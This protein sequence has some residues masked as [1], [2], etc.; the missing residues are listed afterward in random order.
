MTVR[1]LRAGSVC[2]VHGYDPSARHVVGAQQIFI[3]KAG[4]RKGLE[5]ESSLQRFEVSEGSVGSSSLSEG[6]KWFRGRRTQG[7][8]RQSVLPPASWKSPRT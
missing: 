1:S 5:L 3:G 6:I 7:E 2:G 8:G 4:L